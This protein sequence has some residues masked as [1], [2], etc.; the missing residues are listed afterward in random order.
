MV[1]QAEGM[2]SYDLTD[3]GQ[4]IPLAKTLGVEVDEVRPDQVTA[5][6][7]WSPELC[8]SGGV[9]HGGALMAFADTVGA[10][11]AVANLPPGAGTATIESK[12][13][14]FRRVRSGVVTATSKPL[15]IGRTTFVAQ[16]D[17]TDD[18]AQPIAQVTQTQAILLAQR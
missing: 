10:L 14:F 17:L 13:N 11:C 12:T 2:T 5:T 9:M 4:L 18:H 16:T 1:G 15:H 3:V 8:T 6:M 7:R